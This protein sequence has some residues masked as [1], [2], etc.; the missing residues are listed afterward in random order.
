MYLS[1]IIISFV[2]I[3]GITAE[4]NDSNTCFCMTDLEIKGWEVKDQCC[5]MDLSRQPISVLGIT[6]GSSSDDSDV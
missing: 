2:W 4:L 3:M 1:T 6:A 5:W